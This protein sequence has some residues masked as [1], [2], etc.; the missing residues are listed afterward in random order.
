LYHRSSGGHGG[1]CRHVPRNA[2]RRMY[3]VIKVTNLAVSLS[4]R[5]ILKGLTFEVPRGSCAVIMGKNG[6]GKSVLLKTI[7]GLITHYDG[8]IEINNIELSDYRKSAGMGRD[9]RSTLAYVFQRG[10]LFDSMSVFDNVAFGLRRQKLDEELIHGRVLESLQRVGLLG[11]EGKLP[12]ELS[13][14]MQKRVGLARALCQNPDIILYDDPTAGLDPV[15]SDSIADLMGEINRSFHTTSLV[16]THDLKIARKIGNS[17]ALLYDGR[18]VFE[19][20]VDIFFQTDDPFARQF[21]AG[22]TKGPIDLY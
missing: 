7:A 14:G 18:F 3:I 19:D 1:I 4:G 12:S 2:F 5:E 9:E 8:V 15:L 21:I 17:I 20:K 6:S 13:G 22:K 16:T 10:G 11:N